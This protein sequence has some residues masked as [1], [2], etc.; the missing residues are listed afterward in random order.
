[1]SM[2]REEL[3]QAFREVASLEFVDI[4]CEEEIS[5]TFSD[6]FLRKMKEL[7]RSQKKIYWDCAVIAVVCISLFITACSSEAFREPILQQIEKFSGRATN[8][9]VDGDVKNFI[10]HT[11][12][13][14][15]LPEGMELIEKKRS[16][17]YRG[18]IYEDKEENQIHF[19]QYAEENPNIVLMNTWLDKYTIESRGVEVEIYE[20]SDCMI[21]VWV[22][23]GYVMELIYDG[24]RDLEILKE[25]L[26][27]IE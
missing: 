27:G 16:F 18:K 20:Y 2:T 7:I 21:G 10:F 13:L 12:Q 3:K 23:D 14:T 25:I 15:V 22:E 11:Y 19:S 17:R 9:I 26:E 8:H 6:K 5:L 4:P 1:M 24:C